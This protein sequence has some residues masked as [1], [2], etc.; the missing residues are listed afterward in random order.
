MLKSKNQVTL[1]VHQLQE[2]LELSSI[3]MVKRGVYMPKW[4][5]LILCQSLQHISFSHT[6]GTLFWDQLRWPLSCVYFSILYSHASVMLSCMSIW[7]Y[8]AHCKPA[9]TCL[10]RQHWIAH[11]KDA[12]FLSQGVWPLEPGAKPFLLSTSSVVM[13]T[14]THPIEKVPNEMLICNKYVVASYLVV[15]EH[16]CNK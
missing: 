1:F 12:T 16:T 13:L 5:F 15:Y 8:S 11:P 14:A 6:P 10:L 3:N 2:F 7:N 9:K 4:D